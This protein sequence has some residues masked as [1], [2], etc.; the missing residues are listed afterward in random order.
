MQIRHT[1]ALTAALSAPYA[2]AQQTDTAA[3]A[4]ATPAPA[5]TPAAVTLN[6]VLVTGTTDLLSNFLKASLSVQ[7]GADIAKLDLRQVEQDALSTGYLKS[8]TATLQKVSG[9]NIVVLAVIANPNIASVTISGLSF[10]PAD[11]FKTSLANVLNIAP[12]VTLNTVRIDQ[13]TEALIQNFRAEG[14][15]FAPKITTSTK[16]AAKGTVDLSYVVEEST[17]I[18]RVEVTGNTLLPKASIVDAFKPLYDAKKFTPEAYFA[19]I[20]KIQQEYQAA[21]YLASGVSVATSTLEKGVLK[22]A[23]L[24]GRVAAVDLSNLKLPTGKAPVLATKQDGI[25]GLVTL[26]QD[27]RTLSNLSG[28]SV[29][30][31]LQP[32]DPKTPN[33]VKV[34]FGVAEA[35]TGPVKEIKVVGN[36]AVKTPDLLA[37]VKTKVG[38]I[39][40][41]QLAETDFVKLRDVYRTAGYDIST[42]DAVAYKD[43]V[44][45]FTVHET[46]IAGYELT[47]TG[48]K[49]TQERVI[50]R[51][52]PAPG[53]LY[54]SKTFN[55]A[56]DNVTGLGIVKVASINAKA[57]N[58]KEPENLTYQLGISEVSGTRSLPI[59]LQYDTRTG[60]SGSLEIQNNNL[61]GLN[62][63]VGANITAAANDAGQIF[64]GGAQYSI[65]WLDIDFADF[66][67][68]RTSV[69]LS[70]FSN[71]NGNNPLL[72]ASNVD[73]Q[74][75]YTVRT[76]GFGI[77]A[78]RNLTPNIAVSANVGTSFNAYSLEEKKDDDKV[79]VDETTALGLVPA[80]GLITT[81]G[82]GA[83]FDNTNTPAFPTS[84]F[85]VNA[86]ASYNFGRSGVNPLGWTQ[87]RGGVRTYFGVGRTLEKGFGIQQ[88]QQAFAVRLDAGTYIGT[89]PAGTQYFVGGSNPD[90]GLEL[91]AYSSGDFKGTNF[92]TSSAEY[93]YD[94]NLSNSIAQSIYLIGFADAGTAWNAG[95]VPTYGY[96]LGVGTQ[97]D[98]G[99]NNT[100]LAT[101]RFDYGFSPATG[102]GQFH[103]RLGK[104]W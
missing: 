28:Q 60:F 76:T 90:A 18:S 25:P 8:A 79:T 65:P 20:Q 27:V 63:T 94:L 46:R 52:L 24:E 62:H 2:L 37:A 26:E 32:S 101:V 87:L 83:G 82:V 12:G 42:R 69:S 6:N 33:R 9:Q 71:V 66:R 3:P 70:A 104:I 38:D 13:S 61:F 53:T 91:R 103:F 59:G 7:P 73:T 78:G 80:N 16:P 10:L 39:F 45:T 85:R 51:E 97:I 92:V 4:P 21:G 5:A 1:L 49:T 11:G 77:S 99:F 89:Y 84:G 40:S 95:Q 34:V 19:A 102:S 54:N 23:V 58:E 86:S 55:R 96:S 98:L 100:P 14:Y 22:V 31:A 47:W 44:L 15:P 29:G 50:T 72:D 35:V 88:K 75:D 74:R 30:F 41:R 67:T 64:S 93:R 68:N 48:K 56:L 57:T 17:P 43:G 36:T 81:L